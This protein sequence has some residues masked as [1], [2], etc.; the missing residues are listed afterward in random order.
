MCR[1]DLSY[2]TN[3]KK[4]NKVSISNQPGSDS[5]LNP[6]IYLAGLLPPVTRPEE[7]N[8]FPLVFSSIPISEDRGDAGMG[9]FQILSANSGTIPG[10]NSVAALHH[11]VPADHRIPINP[12]NT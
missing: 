4:V 5:E 2:L 7:P 9:K 1:D 11:L 10:C 3:I 12:I 8:L 6:D